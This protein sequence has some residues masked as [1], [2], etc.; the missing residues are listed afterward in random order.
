M[1]SHSAI[2]LPAPGKGREIVAPSLVTTVRRSEPMFSVSARL[3]LAMLV[4]T[5]SFEI[6]R[7][8]SSPAET[9]RTPA[10]RWAAAV[11]RFGP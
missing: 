3:Q 10:A 5:N 7:I 8:Q 2:A 11:S 9:P 6:L 4:A 1:L